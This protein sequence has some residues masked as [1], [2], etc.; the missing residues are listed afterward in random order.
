[1]RGL[2]PE[3]GALALE[4]EDAGEGALEVATLPAASMRSSRKYFSALV[5]TASLS[6]SASLSR[7]SARTAAGNS[8]WSCA[9][10]S[11]AATRQRCR[12]PHS[13]VTSCR[14]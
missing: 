1:V 14:S 3:L 9:N 8:G 5:L 6:C 2:L 13:R 12:L 4:L 10:C 11:I 7:A